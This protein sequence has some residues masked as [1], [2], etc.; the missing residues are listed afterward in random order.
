MGQT[1]EY[2]NAQQQHIDHH[3]QRGGQPEPDQ[4]IV[5]DGQRGTQAAKELGQAGGVGSDAETAH[6]HQTE[7]DMD[8]Q[9][10]PGGLDRRTGI[11]ESV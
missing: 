9:T 7:A 4:A 2:D 6:Q 1:T 8:H 3:G 11:A 5:V 10:Q